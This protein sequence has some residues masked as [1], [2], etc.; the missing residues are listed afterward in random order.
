M[1]Q[2]EGQV[3]T[4]GVPRNIRQLVA[5]QR[6][7]LVPMEHHLLEAASVAGLEFTAAAVAAAVT[8][9][10][11]TVEQHCERLVERQQ[12]L[13]RIGLEEWPDG[14]LNELGASLATARQAERSSPDVS[15][16]L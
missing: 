13:K 14:T 5:K 15:R 6:M 9:D 16:N 7:R 3:F 12:F 1:L 10:T 2:R 11:A 8:M 4:G